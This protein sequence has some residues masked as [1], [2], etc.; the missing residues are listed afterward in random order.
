MPKNAAGNSYSKP[1]GTNSSSSSYHYSNKGGSCEWGARARVHP[2]AL[3]LCQ[4][5]LFVAVS[6]SALPALTLYVLAR[7]RSQNQTTITTTM[8]CVAAPVAC[9][10]CRVRLAESVFGP[11]NCAEYI[12]QCWEW[13]HALHQPIWTSVGEVLWQ[14]HVQEVR[15]ARLHSDV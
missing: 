5:C 13:V 11:M 10:V 4:P 9:P 1:G 6:N 3:C 2:A 12:L 15:V 8:G 7:A 14:H